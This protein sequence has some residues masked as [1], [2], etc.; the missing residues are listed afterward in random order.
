VGLAPEELAVAGLALGPVVDCR[1]DRLYRGEAARP[2]GV[3]RSLGAPGT[4]VPKGRHCIHKWRVFRIVPVVIGRIFH[5]TG[6]RT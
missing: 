1:P 4:S 5:S 2:L 6:Y 3:R